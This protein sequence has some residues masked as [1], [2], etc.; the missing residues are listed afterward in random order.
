LT[1]RNFIQETTWTGRKPEFEDS[2]WGSINPSKDVTEL[3][4]LWDNGIGWMRL[5]ISRADAIIINK[6]DLS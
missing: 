3:A 1:T 4:A 5:T 2:N 6:L